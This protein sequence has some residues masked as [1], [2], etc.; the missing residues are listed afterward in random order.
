ME[1]KC[2]KCS[3]VKGIEDFGKEK[4]PDKNHPPYH[5]QCKE[6]RT[7]IIYLMGTCGCLKRTEFRDGGTV[8]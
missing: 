5:T 7:K 2:W 8:D 3:E 1:Q 6:C 4:Y